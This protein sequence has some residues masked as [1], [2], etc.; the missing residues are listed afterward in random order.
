VLLAGIVLLFRFGLAL[1]AGDTLAKL[2]RSLRGGVGLGEDRDVLP[3]EGD[4][5]E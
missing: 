4:Q 3:G 2:R 1:S 5:V